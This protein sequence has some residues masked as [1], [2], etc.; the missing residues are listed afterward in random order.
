MLGVCPMQNE[1]SIAPNFKEVT[2]KEDVKVYHQYVV[3]GGKV[4]VIKEYQR[5]KEEENQIES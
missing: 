4:K 1:Y 2:P 5:D 3:I